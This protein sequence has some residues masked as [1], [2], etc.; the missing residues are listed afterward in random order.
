MKLVCLGTGTLDPS[1][2]RATSGHLI[3][4]KGQLLTLLDCGFG[5]PQ[6]LVQFGVPGREQPPSRLIISHFHPD[7]IGGLVHYLFALNYAHEPWSLNCPFE[8]F[9]PIGLAE[10]IELI[11]QAFPMTRPKFY[12]LKIVELDDTG[13]FQLDKVNVRHVAVEHGSMKALAYRFEDGEQVFVYSGDTGECSA[14]KEIC[15]D[16]NLFLCECTHDLEDEPKFDS[17]LTTKAAGVIAEAGRV[18]KMV[19][20]HLPPH[21]NDLVWLREVQEYYTGTVVCAKDFGVYLPE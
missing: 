18:K 3:Y 4:R 11:H 8:I 9:G 1:A 19:L 17:H 15:Q 12:E 2:S 21:Q 5:V 20:T 16:A 13:S 7:H 14:I 6:R 10:Q